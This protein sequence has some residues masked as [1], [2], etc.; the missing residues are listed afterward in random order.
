MSKD[1]RRMVADLENNILSGLVLVVLVLMFVLGFRNALFVGLAIPFSMLLTFV[2]IQLSGTTLNMIVLF[3]LVL[4]VGMLVDNAVVVI[5]NIYRHIQEGK[6]PLEAASAGTREVGAAIVVSTLTTVGAFFPLLFWPGVVGDFMFYLPL[7]VSI[8]LAASLTVGL[9]G[10]PGAGRDLHAGGRGRRSGGEALGERP[11]AASR[12]LARLD[13]FARLYRR[14]L[15]WRSTTGRW[16]SAAPSALFVGVVFCSAPSTTA[17]S[18]S[19]RPSRNQILVDVE[20]AARHPARADRRHGARASRRRWRDLP[21]LEV[22]AAG[23]GSGSQSTSARRAATG[24]GAA[25]PRPARPQGPPQSSFLTM[26]RCASGP[27]GSRGDGRGRAAGG[28]AAGRRPAVDRDA[29]DDF[30]TLGAIAARIQEAIADVPGLV[31]LD[32]TTSTSRGRRSS[33]TST[34]PRRRGWA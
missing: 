27:P 19:P 23:A 9:H 7:T 16:W 20:T 4:A 3:S 25:H 18:S 34:A 14:S 31:S 5:E 21:D 2:A 32:S 28:G 30:A 10:Q 33:S 8:A 17:S 1:I 12:R 22:M 6:P 24:P 11:A 26:D 13:R 29:G 15:V